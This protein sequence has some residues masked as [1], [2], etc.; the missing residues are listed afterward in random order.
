MSV[1]KSKVDRT[2]RLV[3]T[4]TVFGG[5]WFLL[6][7]IFK[8]WVR[9]FS[10]GAYTKTI[11][12][13]EYLLLVIILTFVVVI[14]YKGLTY[15]YSEL[16]T[17]QAFENKNDAINSQQNADINF[18]NIFST[19]KYCK[20]AF[21][22]VLLLATAVQLILQPNLK[23]SILIG[24]SLGILILIVF[25][26]VKKERWK[27][28]NEIAKNIEE[29]VS[30]YG[31]MLNIVFFLIIIGICITL[32]SINS[33]QFVKAEFKTDNDLKFDISIQNIQDFRVE[34][35]IYS[36][37]NL[38]VTHSYNIK[39]TDFIHNSIEVTANDDSS[40]KKLFIDKSKYQSHYSMNI[41]KYIQEGK[42][43][44]KI[45]IFTKDPLG[46]KVIR[47]VNTINKSG[48]TLDISE[49]EFI[50]NL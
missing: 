49:E 20:N 28:I 8:L 29:R 13:F 10:S 35:L 4:I 23:F 12:S 11:I 34:I 32:V 44:V 19:I 16:K 46:S 5:A 43:T 22:T 39:K 50:V 18:A 9:T 15:I 21:I 33:N 7:E 47:L 26:W 31:L 48:M 36:N 37:E 1:E 40:N 17:Y 45:N 14:T 42:N 41:K 2:T 30:P 24:I 6:K 38:E 25:R 3:I 27:K